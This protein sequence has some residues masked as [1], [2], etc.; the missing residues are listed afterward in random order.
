M[1]VAVRVSLTK[2]GV[3][4]DVP[5]TMAP[6]LETIIFPFKRAVPLLVPPLEMGSIPLVSLEVSKEGM[7]KEESNLKV[8][9]AGI[10]VEGPAHTVLAV[11]LIK[12]TVSVC[13]FAPLEEETVY[14]E[15]GMLSVTIP[16]AL[17]E[18]VL[19]P[20]PGTTEINAPAVNCVGTGAPPVKPM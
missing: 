7:S 4:E 9:V 10:P 6:P 1:V 15:T 20:G 2:L 8:G 11:W 5:S 3:L 19:V 18:M 14:K 17:V 16:K 13:V 12:L